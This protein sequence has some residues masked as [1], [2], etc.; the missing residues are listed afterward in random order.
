MGHVARFFV[1][2]CLPII[3]AALSLGQNSW[4]FDKSELETAGVIITGHSS[5]FTCKSAYDVYVQVPR[6]FKDRKFYGG[7]LTVRDDSTLLLYTNLAIEDI[8]MTEY[9]EEP[10]HGVSFCIGRSL[11]TKATIHLH[12]GVYIEGEF[13]TGTHITEVIE[14]RNLEEWLE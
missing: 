2:L 14:V 6:K 7:A 12:F 4:V 1:L 9:S 10:F 11:M 3:A 13:G 8:E 5:Q